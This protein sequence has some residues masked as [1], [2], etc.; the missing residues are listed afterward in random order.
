MSIRRDK[1]KALAQRPG[2]AGEEQAAVAALGRMPVPTAQRERLTERV[3]AAL[4]APSTNAKVYR[5]GRSKTGNDYV[6]GFGV[7]V[8]P[9]GTK[10]FVLNYAG[11][12]RKTIGPWPM[13]SVEAAR[14]EATE[15]WHKIQTGSDPAKEDRE[16]RQAQT[17]AELCDVFLKDRADK[18]SATLR[19]YN[20]T[21][22][23]E[24]KP[25]LG[26]HKAASIEGRHIRDLHREIATRERRH[27]DK[28]TGREVVVK[29][30]PYQANRTLATL[31]AVFNMA[32]RDDIIAKNPCTGIKPKP[33]QQ[34]KRYL[35]PDELTRLHPALD[36]HKDQHV[37]DLFRLILTTGARIGEWVQTP[38]RDTPARWLD[39]DLRSGI[40]TKP[41]STKEGRESTITLNKAALAVLRK[42]HPGRASDEAFVFPGVTYDSI[43]DDWKQ[44]MQAARITDFRRH[45]LR[46]TFASSVLKGS[47]N[48]VAVKELLGHANIQTT[49]RYLHVLDEDL[50]AAS[51]AAGKLL[52]KKRPR[53]K[54]G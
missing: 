53:V 52:A 36:A 19:M 2:T 27:I 40:W 1:V 13:W 16:R 37:A 20:Q 29:G 23:A 11:D 42:Y 50:R 33:E 30:A 10:S 26:R 45:D 31:K 46:H 12:K 14:A 9:A 48:L 25:V 51:E 41:T 39:L 47:K 38:F 22:N 6:P 8:T 17:V 5:D 35:K 32:I 24:I 49:S 21:I 15:L 44:L 54:A 7:R 34:R 18:R 3:V 43:R 4:P 28:E